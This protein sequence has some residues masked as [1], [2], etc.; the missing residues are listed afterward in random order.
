MKAKELERLT[1]KYL[2]P[3][4][5][6]FGSTGLL[7]YATPVDYFLRGFGFDRSH[8][9]TREFTIWAFIQPLY[10]PASHAGFN[11][12][13]RL[14]ALGGQQE[15]WWDLEDGAQQVA[16]EVLK[17]MQVEGIPFLDQIH[18]PHDFVKKVRELADPDEPIVKEA[19]CY[20]L[21]LTGDHSKGS[22]E[23][24][25]LSRNIE[26]LKIQYP[27]IRWL[28]DHRQRVLEVLAALRISP[29]SARTIL[30]QWRAE[31]LAKLKLADEI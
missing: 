3:N 27:Y 2:L 7:I 11:T 23:L 13:N 28:E 4:L 14:G 15:H 12:G 19:W 8:Y 1:K 9:R 31:T 25:R 20:A 6:G 30:D 26:E 17:S 16:K 29:D 10:I 21:I 5:P 22:K 24:E 18:S